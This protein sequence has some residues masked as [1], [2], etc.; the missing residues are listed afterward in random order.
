MKKIYKIQINR[1][2]YNK[3]IYMN[4]SQNNQIREFKS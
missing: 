2:N 3:I 1:R 4:K